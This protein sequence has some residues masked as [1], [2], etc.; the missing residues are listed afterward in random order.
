MGY[1]RAVTTIARHTISDEVGRVAASY[2]IRRAYLFGSCARGETDESS[3]A[4][5]CIEPERGFT[6]FMLAGFGDELERALR[7]R[8][9]VV[10]GE[11]SLYPHV[12]RR[13]EDEKVLLYERR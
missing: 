7:R 3:N 1:N 11:D 9:D 4:D 2:P 12:R 13:Y 8:V 10:C 5:V 6:L